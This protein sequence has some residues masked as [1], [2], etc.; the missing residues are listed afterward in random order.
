M[1]TV[2]FKARIKNG[3]IEVPKKY[4][5]KF[6]DSVRVILI[7]ESPKSKAVHYL[8]ELM[9]HPFKAVGFTPLSRDEVY[10]RN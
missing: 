6:K 7:I 1:E 2:E 3:L 9:A 8:D 4:Q 10:A 5:A